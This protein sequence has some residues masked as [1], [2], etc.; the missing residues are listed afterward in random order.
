MNRSGLGPREDRGS[1]GPLV[2]SRRGLSMTTAACWLAVTLFG[3]CASSGGPRPATVTY[4]P[5][6]SDDG[7][8]PAPAS[9]ATPGQT[10]PSEAGHDG[11]A[12]PE[13]SSPSSP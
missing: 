8:R 3:A 10:S 9:P 7:L 5:M 6:P 11:G 12:A 2:A 13:S 4:T 1:R